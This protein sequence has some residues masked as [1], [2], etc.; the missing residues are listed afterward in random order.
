MTRRLARPS[1]G[2]FKPFL[3]ELLGTPPVRGM[4]R[5]YLSH[6]P[7]GCAAARWIGELS[8]G[9]Q[10]F[11]S[12]E[13]GV[14]AARTRSWWCGPARG[15]LSNSATGTGSGRD[16]AVDHHIRSDDVGRMTGGR[17]RTA[18]TISE[19]RAT[20]PRANSGDATRSFTV[21]SAGIGLVA[22]HE[23][24]LIALTRTPSRRLGRVTLT[25]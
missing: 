8:G 5:R 25:E 16:A 1:D 22:S 21:S 4:R 12:D 19:S 11:V 17:Y 13:V 24:E 3:P 15:W 6:S 23:P 14:D 20:S 18:A 7:L 10:W 9:E 2:R